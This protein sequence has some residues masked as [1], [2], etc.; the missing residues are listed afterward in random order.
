MFKHTQDNFF[1]IIQ[2]FLQVFYKVSW[3][4]IFGFLIILVVSENGPLSLDKC[5]IQYKSITN[6]LK[7]TVNL[8]GLC[9]VDVVLGVYLNQYYF[10]FSVLIWYLKSTCSYMAKCEAL[11]GT[12]ERPPRRAAWQDHPFYFPSGHI[13]NNDSIK[14][15]ITHNTTASITI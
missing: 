11:W 15:Q 1:F 9:L 5:N 3:S 7:T 14:S 8:L 2:I 6:K 13:Y 10:E 12:A 4:S